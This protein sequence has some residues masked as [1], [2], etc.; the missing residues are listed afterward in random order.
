MAF[1]FSKSYFSSGDKF[2]THCMPGVFRVHTKR[3]DQKIPLSLQNLFKLKYLL[4]FVV[5]LFIIL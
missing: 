1:Q 5:L 2:K 3:I 4:D